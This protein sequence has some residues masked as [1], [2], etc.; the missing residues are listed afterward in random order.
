[1]TIPTA[2]PPQGV[3][4]DLAIA[5]E[6][7]RLGA[8]L[9][10]PEVARDALAKAMVLCQH[11]PSS[12]PAAVMLFIG[13]GLIRKR[14]G[15]AVVA[16]VNAERAKLEGDV[17]LPEW[18]ATLAQLLGMTLEPPRT[19]PCDSRAEMLDRAKA[20]GLVIP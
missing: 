17:P 16:L 6:L 2:T 3:A 15:G 4:Q 14:I 10:P 1:M 11:S 12:E 19:G 5:D 18:A 13:A 8:T 20:A 7:A 9:L